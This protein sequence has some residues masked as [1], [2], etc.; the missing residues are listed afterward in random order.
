MINLSPPT[1]TPNDPA[2][3]MPSDSVQTD[4]VD[5]VQTDPVGP[6]LEDCEAL[7]IGLSTRRFL[8][9]RPAERQAHFWPVHGGWEKVRSLRPG[10]EVIHQGV[11][12]TVRAIE[13]YR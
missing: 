7:L 3:S 6:T 13:V 10:D 8:V 1:E 5:S 4:S 12:A 11:K 9:L 2:G